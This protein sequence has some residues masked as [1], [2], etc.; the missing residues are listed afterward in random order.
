MKKK[1]LY[2]LNPDK[3]LL[4]EQVK[5]I[6]FHDYNKIHTV[7]IRKNGYFITSNWEYVITDFKGNIIKK[8]H[9][10][11]PGEG[12]RKIK[13]IGSSV[14]AMASARVYTTTDASGKTVTTVSS[15][16]NIVNDRNA[17]KGAYI[18]KNG[19]AYE[20]LS[21]AL[22]TPERFN[23]FK[24]TKNSSF[25]YTKK[26]SEKVLLQ[27]DKDNGDL[28]EI[29]KFDVNEPKYKIDKLAKRIYFRNGKELK[30]FT[31]N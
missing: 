10:L 17:R 15:S 1:K 18:S 9:F 24:T 28:L 2:V 3:G 14:F 7:E 31:Y 25:F 19:E 5:K 11:Q 8:E 16:A 29:F 26:D 27:I 20:G 6:D 23:A 30:I 4:D 21:N 22:Y 13:N 12:F